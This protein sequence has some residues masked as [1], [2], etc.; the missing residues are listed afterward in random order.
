MGTQK[1]LKEIKRRFSLTPYTRLM[2]VVL[3]FLEIYSLL[4]L[5]SSHVPLPKPAVHPAFQSGVIHVHSIFS[6]G[7]GTIPEIATAAKSA[8]IDFVVV[9]DHNDSGARRHGFEKNY[10]GVDVFVEMEASAPAGHL[11][12][13]YSHTGAKDLDDKTINQ[14]A[15]KHYL[16]EDSRPGMFTVVAHPSNIKNPWTHLDKFPDGMEIINFDSIWQQQAS[17]ALLN[18]A[19]TVLIMPWNNYLAAL[20]FFEPNP[21]DL[22]AWDAMNSVTPG[23]FGILAH[24]TH[25]KLKFA[26]G[27]S[28]RFPDYLSTFRLASNVV[29]APSPLPIDFAERKKLIYEAL[30]LGKAAMIF[31]S[32]YPYAGNDWRLECGDKVYRVGDTT[33][34]GSKGCAFTVETPHGLPY[35]H[36]IRLWRNGE[37][38]GEVVSTRQIEQLPI[39]RPGMYRAEVWVKAHS[40]MF[41]A[42]HRPTPYVFYNPI[43]V[44]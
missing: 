19:A 8:G 16:R 43:Y 28:I 30:R 40:L 22:V 34:F 38:A 3:L 42:L 15:W 14:L 36:L 2:W 6:D 13:F 12:A 20:R 23:H 39:E 9:T 25:A 41:L 4:P 18:F 7:G 29:F 21:K 44:R 1:A 35:T 5:P 27:N 33:P 32:I 17:D 31:Q 37:L 24:D 26:P 10:S 11:L